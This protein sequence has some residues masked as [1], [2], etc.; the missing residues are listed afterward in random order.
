M[1]Q[2]YSHHIKPGTR[3]TGQRFALSQLQFQTRD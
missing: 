2:A 1:C 3:E